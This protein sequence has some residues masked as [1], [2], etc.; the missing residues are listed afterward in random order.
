MFPLQLTLMIVLIIGL[1]TAYFM[2]KRKKIS[3]PKKVYIILS[4]TL[5]VIF[6]FRYMLGD[7]FLSDTLQLVN[8]NFETKFQIFV[9]LIANWL[10]I[11]NVLLIV[12]YPFFKNDGYT[13]IIKYFSLPISIITLF[14]IRAISTGVAGGLG[15]ADWDFRCILIGL[16]IAITFVMSF[17]IFME[18]DRFKSKKKDLKSLLWI[19]GVLGSTMPIYMLQALFGEKLSALEILDFNFPHRIILYLSFIVPLTIYFLLRKR[20][21]E[22]IRLCLLYLSL[23]ALISFMSRYRFVDFLDVTAWPFHLCHTAMYIIPLCLIFKWEKV[24][25]FTYF[26]N[27]LGAFLAMAMPNYSFANDFFSSN[28]VNFYINH[29]I[30]FFMPLLIVMLRVYPRPRLKQFKYSMIGFGLYFLLVLIFNAWFSNY[31]SVDYFYINTDFI[32]EKLGKWAEDLRNITWTLHIS[33]LTLVFYPLYQFIY[34]V[35]YCFLG[36]GMWF[37]YEAMYIFEDTI[38][39]ILEIKKKIKA[40][41]LALAVAL[42]DRD[43][44]EPMNKDGVNKLI[45]NNFSKRYGTSDVYAVKDAN[46]EINGGEIFGFLGHNGAGKSTIIKSIV[47]IQPITSGSIQVCGYDVDKQSVDAKRHIGFVPD[48]YALY[49]KLTGR[50]YINYI[51]DLYDVS[52]EDRNKCIEKYVT[53][54]ELGEAFDNQIKTYSHGMKQKITIISALVHNP[55]VWILDE[56]LTGLDPTSIFQVKECMREH[57]KKGNIVFFS[58]HLIDIVESLCDKVAIIKKGKILTCKT[59]KEIEESGVPL[60]R[61]YLE[62]TMTNV[63]HVQFKEQEKE[64]FAKTRAKEKEEKKESLLRKKKEKEEKKKK[65]SN[66]SK[67]KQIKETK[68]ASKKNNEEKE[69][70]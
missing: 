25:Y 35:V 57:A 33:D 26:I 62:T 51:A 30:A 65:L 19:I 8:P 7:D 64:S 10:L 20:D 34:Y 39:D 13:T 32:A 69:T 12:L 6:F 3:I 50:E 61:F 58:S 9:S 38:I 37:L 24:F 17:V 67:D 45:I 43:K 1:I 46:L 27:V 59:I 56:P 63:N 70:K 55:K 16:E 36:A 2:F 23:G 53:L 66:L 40:D 49:E 28:I 29:F 44:G 4:L 48:H 18:N 22:F 52:L 11:A 41:A 15:Y 21:S 68:K 54:F 42:G 14:S 60:E 5:A 47:G 31:G